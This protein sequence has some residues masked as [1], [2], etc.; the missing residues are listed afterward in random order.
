MEEQ[1][2]LVDCRGQW[3]GVSILKTEDSWSRGGRYVIGT[4]VNKWD[5]R[6]SDHA[7]FAAWR[8]PLFRPWTCSR[9][10]PLFRV[11]VCSAAPGSGFHCHRP[12]LLTPQLTVLS[13]GSRGRS[14]CRAGRAQ[15]SGVF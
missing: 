6:D 7:Q 10:P 14:L 3:E 5:N 15:L 2:T 12:S 13:W 1:R 8:G 11:L 4:K 9:R